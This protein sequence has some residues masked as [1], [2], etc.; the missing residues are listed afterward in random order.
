[1]IHIPTNKEDYTGFI[2]SN[3]WLFNL[4]MRNG[5]SSKGTKGD[6]GKVDEALLRGMRDELKKEL[7]GYAFWDVFN[8][9]EL[10]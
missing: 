9:D 3:G 7:E 10:A 5:L 2:L 6:D 1:M 8:C 4:K